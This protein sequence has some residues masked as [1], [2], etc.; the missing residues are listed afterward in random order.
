MNGNDLLQLLMP[1]IQLVNKLDATPNLPKDIVAW[2]ERVKAIR[3]D[4]PSEIDEVPQQAYQEALL[5]V[6]EKVKKAKVY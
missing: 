4:G 3:S 1:P 6:E 5:V 2:V